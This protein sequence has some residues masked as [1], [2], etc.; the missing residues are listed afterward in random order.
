MDA[1]SHVRILHRKSWTSL[2]GIVR[3]DFSQVKSK[4]KQTKTF[5]DILKQTPTYELEME[6]IQREKPDTAIVESILRHI[7]FYKEWG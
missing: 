2:D 4:T 6:V 3:Y 5:A 7:Y 1:V